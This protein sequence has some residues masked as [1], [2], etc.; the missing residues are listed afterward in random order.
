MR[1]QSPTCHTLLGPMKG[2]L[3]VGRRPEILRNV[4]RQLGNDTVSVELK[5][6][7]K[8]QGTKSECRCRATLVLGCMS[9]SDEKNGTVSVV[10]NTPFMGPTFARVWWNPILIPVRGSALPTRAIGVITSLQVFV[11]DQ[12]AY[13]GN[14]ADAV[15]RLLILTDIFYIK[16]KD[17]CVIIFR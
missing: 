4:R 1:Y 10:G 6:S 17:R 3:S 14:C 16:V 12:W 8:C 9:V 2:G 15:D 13:V 7:V 5:W 11:C